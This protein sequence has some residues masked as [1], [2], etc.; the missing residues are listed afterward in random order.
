MR[1]WLDSA[2]NFVLSGS[3][4]E[5]ELGLLDEVT[6]RYRQAG[7]FEPWPFTV[8]ITLKNSGINCLQ[9]GK[10]ICLNTNGLTAWTIAHE[11]AHNWDAANGWQ[12]SK[13]M[14][15]VTH[16]GFVCAALHRLHPAWQLFW[17]RVGSPPP[18]CGIDRNFN[19]VEDFAESVTSYLYPEEAARRAIERGYPYAKWGFQHFHETPRGKHIRALFNP[20]S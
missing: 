19:A 18:P 9:G 11:L 5:R 8:N 4:R 13:E 17:Y 6:E 12:L 20:S 15:R 7:R 14:R 1:P 3:W 10:N 2:A 16:S